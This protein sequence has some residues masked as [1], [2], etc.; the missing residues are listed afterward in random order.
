MLRNNLT[1]N[2]TMGLVDT[3]TDPKVLLIVASIV[4]IGLVIFFMWK[5]GYRDIKKLEQSQKSLQSEMQHGVLLDSNDVSSYNSEVTNAD[6]E[7]KP[8][9]G[10]DNEA[11]QEATSQGEEEAE[12]D[13]ESEDQYFLSADGFVPTSSAARAT[14]A[15]SPA[16]DQTTDPD[17][18][19]DTNAQEQDVEQEEDEALRTD[20]KELR[21]SAD[22]YILFRSENEVPLFSENIRFKDVE[23]VLETFEEE[24]VV[25]DD[26]GDKIT[27]LPEAPTEAGIDEAEEVEFS[28]RVSY[29]VP[30]DLSEIE[31]FSQLNDLE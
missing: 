5:K 21:E 9:D 10:E 17:Q 3:L 26:E 14:A 8:V 4:V 11:V 1:S 27:L 20:M 28:E 30:D 15:T 25:E 2:Q 13:E 23:T 22:A 19:E 12:A 24:S 31:S 7:D 29:S 18:P 16:Q 6:Q